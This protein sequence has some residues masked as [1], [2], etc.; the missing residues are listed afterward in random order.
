MN[1]MLSFSPLCL[2]LARSPLQ[3][4]DISS[5]CPAAQKLALS[6][7]VNYYIDLNPFVATFMQ[8]AY[9]VTSS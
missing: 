8:A 6:E 4:V 3:F 1:T 2:S 9:E 7:D 5:F